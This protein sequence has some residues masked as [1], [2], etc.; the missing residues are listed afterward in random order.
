MGL[1]EIYLSCYNLFFQILYY[2]R[3]NKR[4]KAVVSMLPCV[5]LERRNNPQIESIE[6]PCFSKNQKEIFAVCV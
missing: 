3:R 5:A 6:W 2:R 4:P 1:S